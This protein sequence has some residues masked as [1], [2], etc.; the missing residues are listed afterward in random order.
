MTM[1]YINLYYITLIT[2]HSEGNVGIHVV[3]FVCFHAPCINS[4]DYLLADIVT[5]CVA[6]D[7]TSRQPCQ[8][9]GLTTHVS[10]SPSEE[11]SERGPPTSTVPSPRPPTS[12]TPAAVGDGQPTSGGSP[13][14][15]TSCSGSCDDPPK[16]VLLP[17]TTGDEDGKAKRLQV[18]HW[19]H[20]RK[21]KASGDSHE[22]RA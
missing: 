4:L 20:G 5:Q 6:T 2:L 10:L 14:V 8:S 1:R 3:I 19:S 13:P 9:P 21:R 16:L 11:A 7:M 18:Q 17:L 12:H 22:V 15:G